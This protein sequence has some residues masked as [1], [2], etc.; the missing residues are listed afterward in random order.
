MAEFSYGERLLGQFGGRE[1]ERVAVLASVLDPATFSVLESIGVGPGWRCL[2]AGAGAGSVAR[3]LAGRVAPAT[4][5]AADRDIRFL[6]DPAEPNLVVRELDLGTGELPAAAFDLVFARIVLLHLRSREAVLDR[7][8][9]ALAP[10]GYL[11]I[12]ETVGDLGLASSCPEI[13]QCMRAVLEVQAAVLGTDVTWVRTLPR[14]L[15]G[16]GLAD[17]GLRADTPAMT[18]GDNLARS[19]LMTL[20]A[21]ADTAME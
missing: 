9:R 1:Q 19:F 14:R 15:A 4:V 8:C 18:G 2:D 3:W 11:V 16:L 7:L 6:G 5:V 21:L 10:G 17:I 13:R 12:S 20:D